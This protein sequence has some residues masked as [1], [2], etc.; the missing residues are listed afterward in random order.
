M[1]SHVLT[2]SA[3]G[4]AAK[5]GRYRPETLPQPMTPTRVRFPPV[6]LSATWLA[7]ALVAAPNAIA[8][9]PWAKERSRNSRRSVRWASTA[10]LR[11]TGLEKV[12][13]LEENRSF[14]ACEM[15]LRL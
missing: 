8:T 6:G 1:M 12:G 11:Y 4:Q 15:S 9:A 10:N 2:N 14:R 7:F 3:Y 5:S 13:P